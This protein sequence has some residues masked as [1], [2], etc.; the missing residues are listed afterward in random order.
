MRALAALML[1]STLAGCGEFKTTN[2]FICINGPDVAVEYR[3][4]Q[5][6]LIFAGGR[7]ETL[8]NTPERPDFYQ[9]PDITWQLTGFRQARLN[10][11]QSSLRC[12]E[13][14]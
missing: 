11:G 12:D 10:D 14:G 5:V 8:Q 9:A 4:D 1:L 2:R 13:V 7:A 3:G 6:R